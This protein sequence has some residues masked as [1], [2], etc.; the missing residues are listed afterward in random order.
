MV[1]KMETLLDLFGWNR[2]RNMEGIDGWGKEERH[3]C[4]YQSIE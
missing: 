4:G 2:S 1:L 3:N